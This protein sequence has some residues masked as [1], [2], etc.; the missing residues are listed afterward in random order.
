MA[1]NTAGWLLLSVACLLACLPPPASAQ[2]KGEDKWVEL[3]LRGWAPTF[4]GSIQSAAN[5]NVGADLDFASQLGI[6]TQQ[7]FL[8]PKL[9]PRLPDRHRLTAHYMAIQYAGDSVLEQEVNFG[10]TTFRIGEQIRAEFD[11]KQ[12]GLTYEYDVLKYERFAAF[13]SLRLD[14]L[15]IEAEVRG[16]LIGTRRESATVPVP[17]GGGGLRIWPFDWLKIGGRVSGI[18]GGVAG[19]EGELVDAEAF[20]AV[21]PW[22]WLGLGVGYRYYRGI[23]RDEE[24]GDQLDWLQKGPFVSLILRPF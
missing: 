18:K 7:N 12:G 13:L 19:Y 15:S 23:G 2:L 4:S 6:D 10:G 14:V 22:H 16:D 20:A 5:G 11:L 17:T 1:Q 8:L 21:S 9:I 24:T 3:E